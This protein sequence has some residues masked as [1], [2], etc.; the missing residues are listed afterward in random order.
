MLRGVHS[1]SLSVG[2]HCLDGS[3][4]W[5]RLLWVQHHSSHVL[6][7]WNK[8]GT[9]YHDMIIHLLNALQIIHFYDPTILKK[10]KQINK[11]M[12]RLKFYL[13]WWTRFIAWEVELP[14][15]FFSRESDSR[16]ANVRP[17]VGP[18]VRLSQKPLRLSELLLLTIEPI[19]HRAYWPLSLSA[20]EPIDHQA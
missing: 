20:I 12:K 9:V 10:T 15:F 19:G 4:Y 3:W 7:R 17:S 8:S 11:E 6:S 1:G 16:I 14:C 5:G 2:G 13:C 18:S